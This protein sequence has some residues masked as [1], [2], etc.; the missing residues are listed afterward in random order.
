MW[1]NSYSS[2]IVQGHWVLPVSK[3]TTKI[4]II[5]RIDNRQQKLIEWGIGKLNWKWVSLPD[6][7][8][9]TVAA[10]SLFGQCC[11]KFTGSYSYMNTTWWLCNTAY[12]IDA[13]QI[14]VLCSNSDATSITGVCG[15]CILL[16]LWSEFRSASSA[17]LSEWQHR[18]VK[19]KQTNIKSSFNCE[20]RWQIF[21]NVLL[22][23]S[24]M[25]KM[26]QLN[27]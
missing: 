20:L 2:S 22:Q 11:A 16:L 18:E 24:A 15:T 26:K 10:G 27:N 1:I 19:S 25:C 5:N 23:L 14:C 17:G 6:L 12:C 7:I 9:V 4:D 13:V 3:T 8:H 21:W